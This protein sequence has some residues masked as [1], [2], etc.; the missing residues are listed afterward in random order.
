M[1]IKK[2]L[3]FLLL[4]ITSINTA[5]ADEWTANSSAVSGLGDVGSLSTSSI[6]LD[7]DIYKLIAGE[8]QGG[9]YGYYWSGSTW[10]SDSSIVTGLNDIGYMNS[11]TIFNDGGTWKLISGERGDIF[12]HSG[13][14]FYG[15]YWS[16]STWVS[17]SDIVDGLT[18]VG[19]FGKPTVFLD[20]ST[21]K[22]ISG[23]DAGDFWGWYWSGSTWIL[24]SNVVSGLDDIGRE[25]APIVYL[26]DETL[27]LISGEDS[28][29]FYA[30]YWNGT[31]WISNTTLITG[32]GD[33][34]G[35][36]TPTVF[37]N[38]MNLTL[39]SGEGDGIFNG[40]TGKSTYVPPAPTPTPTPIPIVA[41]P[42]IITSTPVL[43]EL[44]VP[45]EKYT[46]VEEFMTF[47]MTPI[48]WIFILFAYIGA[49][50][51]RILIDPNDGDIKKTLAAMGLYG[52]IGWILVLFA[53]I[54]VELITINSLFSIVI[55]FISGLI[56]STAFGL[57]SNLD[58]TIP[59][60]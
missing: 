5:S 46:I 38:E 52:T 25:S 1:N 9:W 28:G 14:L 19:N 43:I 13:A 27:I 8:F 35:Y 6:F 29:D 16:G 58:K 45:E 22:L 3:I 23:R 33:V 51:G 4:I 49:L 32:L 20:G 41:I 37:D 54:F 40:F 30:Y 12:L 2:L 55:F 7:G 18:D 10:I 47:L 34:G 50:I 17:D 26:D 60:K 57:E 53:N 11:P 44:P 36:S 59:N 15:W 21:L 31:S 56:V 48:S 24:D 42:S 39:I